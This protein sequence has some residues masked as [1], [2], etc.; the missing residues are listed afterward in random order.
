M[1]GGRQDSVVVL[2][3]V[4]GGRG[5]VL[6]RLSI[7]VGRWREE[8]RSILGVAP[9]RWAAAGIE[10]ACGAES[11]VVP[12]VE[13]GD[14]RS[15]SRAMEVGSVGRVVINR[16]SV[17][18]LAEAHC[19]GPVALGEILSACARAEATVV[20]LAPR[21]S[22]EQRWVFADALDVGH[23]RLPEQGA[24]AAGLPAMVE[25]TAREE[26]TAT[27][28]HVFGSVDVT[29]VDSLT[30]AREEAVRRLAEAGVSCDRGTRATAAFVVAGDEAVVAAVRAM[31]GVRSDEVVHARDVKD[32]LAA[33]EAS[34]GERPHLILIG[35]AS[36]LRQGAT[37]APGERRSHVLVAPGVDPRSAEA[38]GRAAEA[39]RPHYLVAQL[40]QPH[41]TPDERPVWRDA[42]VAFVEHRRR[43]GITDTSRAFGPASSTGER[44]HSGERTADRLVEQHT[45]ERQAASVRSIGRD[46]R[47]GLPALAIGP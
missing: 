10:A 42:A 11:V 2:G 27:V 23:G 1:A 4:P 9:G 43:W 32:T 45:L 40:G 46:R 37:A 15:P 35:G 30:A 26:S 36:V 7:A 31:P 17:V 22:L 5:E 6:D 21:R 33:F 29:L 38:R 16:D 13:R 41:R 44:A 47:R 8:G 3:Y 19:Y 14:R 12:G 18:L 25:S 39:A 20:L 34:P 28:S 24:P